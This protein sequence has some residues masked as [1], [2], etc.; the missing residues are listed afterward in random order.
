[1]WKAKPY[2]LFEKKSQEESDEDKENDD[3]ESLKVIQEIMDLL[4]LP[5]KDIL[6]DF[7]SVNQS[8]SI[9]H[10]SRTISREAKKDLE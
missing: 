5:E 10:I 8:L 1:M 2:T 3:G 7:E 4:K 9:Y 6:F